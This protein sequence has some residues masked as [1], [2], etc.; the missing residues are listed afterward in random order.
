MNN[1]QCISDADLARLWDGVL[2]SQ[3]RE[4]L[5]QHMNIC[6]NCRTRWQQMSE[7]AK[8]MEEL[9]FEPARKAHSRH[10]CL[11]DDLL[12]GFIDETLDSE[13]RLMVENH[14]A[15]CSRCR[16][17]LADRFTDAYIKEGDTWWSQYTAHQMLNLFL[18]VPGQI[19]DL[20][21]YLN[22]K[23]AT[24][25]SEVIIKLPMLQP[26]DSEARRL[27]AATGEGFFT[28][29]LRQD[30]PAFEFELVQFG[31][32]VRITA[33]SLKEGSPYKNCLARLELFEEDSC[34][35]SRVVLIDKGQ[36]QCVL[37]P[38]DARG[39]R[40][41]QGNLTIK[42]TPI[43][44]LKQL[45]L[46]GDEAYMPILSKLV[47]HDEPKIRLAAVQVIARIYGP[48]ARSLIE[49]LADDK[50]DMVRQAVKQNLNLFPESKDRSDRNKK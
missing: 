25:R 12:T 34:R 31:E 46:A 35:W 16:D 26:V 9:L 28:Q 20:L 29:T 40:P 50:D 4:V 27:A 36:G 45:A 13:K 24:V 42:L 7:G 14:I 21:E 49:P 41:Q 47:R 19:N 15:I 22:I 10:R 6:S 30:D 1:Q 33:Q 38:K 11:S 44:T 43:V 48:K 32:Q 8:H 2:T 3:E 37:E 39:L 17:S 5:Q 23:A 18:Q